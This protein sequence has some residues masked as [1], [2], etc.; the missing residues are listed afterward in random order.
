M[1]GKRCLLRQYACACLTLAEAAAS[2]KD[3]VVLLEMAPLRHQLA[4]K[5]E[6]SEPEARSEQAAANN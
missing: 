2:P 6:H 5:R 1:E 4:L 3:R